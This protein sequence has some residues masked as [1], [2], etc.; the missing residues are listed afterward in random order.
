M[1]VVS[2]P[3]KAR[4]P[5]TCRRCG[6][7][8]KGHKCPLQLQLD[9]NMEGKNRM[10]RPREQEKEEGKDVDK[11][12]KLDEEKV[13]EPLEGDEQE[14][15]EE[16]DVMEEED[17]QDSEKRDEY[18]PPSSPVKK[19]LRSTAAVETAALTST[20]PAAP[21]AVSPQAPTSAFPVMMPALPS[22]PN[23]FWPAAPVQLPSAMSRPGQLH[24]E[25]PRSATNTPSALRFQLPQPQPPHNTPV[26][27]PMPTPRSPPTPA[28]QEQAAEQP[29]SKVALNRS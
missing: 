1:P 8:K 9:M 2:T 26:T 4:R 22:R 6:V 5:V 28:R 13:Q 12:V 14:E 3:K 27:S 23:K 7:P 11:K 20:L 21:M 15:D 25:L 10:K 18:S 19:R 17:E 16:G 24:A 29:P